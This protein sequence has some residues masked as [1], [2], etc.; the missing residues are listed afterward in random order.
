[1][2]QSGQRVLATRLEDNYWYPGSV[3]RVDEQ[4]CFVLFD[5]GAEHWIPD[6]Q[7]VPL[8]IGA[9]DRLF[10]R[11][12]GGSSYTPC[13]VLRRDGEKLSIQFDDGADEQT[14]IGMVR[15]DPTEWKDPGGAEPDT[16]WIVGDRVLGKWSHDRYW[17]PGTI[18]VIENGKLHVY[19]DDGDHEWMTPDRVT[20]IDL[21]AGQRVFG[22][23]QRGPAYYPGRITRRDGDRIHVRYEDGQEEST[24]IGFVRV[25]RG[26]NY[27]PW[28][29]GQRVLAHWSFE[30]FFYPAVVQ[31][32]EDDVVHVHY[33]DGQQAHLA[34][35]AVLPL[36]LKVGDHVYCK[37]DGDQLYFPAVIE[38][39]DGDR[40]FL[41]YDDGPTE[42]SQVQHLRVLPQE[43]PGLF[44]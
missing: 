17:Y 41:R 29:V 10:V 42:W 24:T 3:H 14:S 21:Q 38:R 13:R 22:R 33:D 16:G 28:K 6:D 43:L 20:A 26:P 27:N 30:P 37:R 18:Q 23:W 44:Q 25:S 7:I 19:F 1:M 4:R 32:I 8:E 5:D 36:K 40:L 12:P 11:L 31:A 15:V 9:G 34:Q 35:D 39:K 2:W